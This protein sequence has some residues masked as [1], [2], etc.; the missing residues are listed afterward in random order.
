M[1]LSFTHPH[2]DYPETKKIVR[3]EIYVAANLFT[4]IHENSCQWEF[5]SDGNPK[6]NI[7]VYII[8]KLV[9][10]QLDSMVDTK[11]YI[12]AMSAGLRRGLK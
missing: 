6:G 12:N 2:K 8:N 9:T 5:I 7:P 11:K 4:P 3:G 10:R 1:T